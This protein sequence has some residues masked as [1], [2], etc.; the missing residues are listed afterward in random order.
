MQKRRSFGVWFKAQVV[1]K[2]LTGIKST[3][4]V[5]REHGIKETLLSRRKQE[6]MERLTE[7]FERQ[8]A[9]THRTCGL[10]RRWTL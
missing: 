2:V 3:A 5:Y 4:Q 9:K 8:P 1:L 6:F 10:L 7:L